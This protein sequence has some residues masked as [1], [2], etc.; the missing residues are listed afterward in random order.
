MF[1]TLFWKGF[2]HHGVTDRKVSDLD[3][4]FIYKFWTILTERSGVKLMVSTSRH[5]KS[6]GASEIMN[7]MMENSLKSYCSYHQDDWD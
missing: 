2:K 3:R 1:L 4:K 5:P 7:I 6:D